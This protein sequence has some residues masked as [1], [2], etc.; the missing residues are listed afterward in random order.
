M[1]EP[2]QVIGDVF[3][4]LCKGIDTPVSLAAW[5]RFKYDQKSLSEQSVN[6]A[7]YTS[8]AHFAPD[9]AVVSF[10]SKFEG[11][12]T[13]VDT[14]EV[15]LS[16]FAAAELRCRDTNNRIRDSMLRGFSPRVEAV[17]HTAKRKIA[18]VL[19]P[20]NV[21]KVLRSPGWGP[22]ATFDLPRKRAMVGTKQSKVPTVT[23]G[24]LPYA[25]IW[26]ETDHHWFQAISGH[27]V[28]GPYSVLPSCFKIVEGNRVI[29]VPK[30]AKTD[31]TI[32]AEPTF[33]GFLQKAVG[34]YMRRRLKRSGVD[35]DNQ[36]INQIWAS[37]ALELDLATI[38]LKA[39]SDTIARELVFLLLPLDWALFLD[40]L[41]S[42]KGKV[43][44]KWITY[45]K[46]SSMGNSFTFELETLIFWALTQGVSQDSAHVVAVYG[47]DIICQKAVA[48]DL[49][50]VLGT[51][52]FETNESK[53]YVTGAFYESC[54]KHYFS[55]RDVTP[56][57]QKANIA[58]DAE[59]IR[60][61][62]RLIRLAYRWGRG[63]YLDSTVRPAWRAL[64]RHA[65]R[66]LRYEVPLHPSVGDD[67][68]SVPRS[69]FGATNYCP[70]QGY[71]CKV[72]SFVPSTRRDDVMGL[73]ANT[74]RVIDDRPEAVSPMQH[75]LPRKSAFDEEGFTRSSE[76]GAF[77]PG[78]RWVHPTRDFD[79]DW[80]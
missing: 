8:A 75:G 16:G 38:D 21:A 9:Y 57:Y 19:G 65:V 59:A 35:L 71:H 54:G 76:L 49:I 41:R 23:W 31:R 63:N 51:L 2:S 24:A 46:F 79:T 34:R 42:P 28:V 50:D 5:L 67:G 80:I 17:L 61:G 36:E 48:A 13:G 69:E 78:K 55:G 62:N 26:L 33:N 58:N 40:S 60:C 14:K 53:S 20:L 32:A 22:G 52:G 44:G 12:N 45:E 6:P 30:N 72:L 39:A 47:D 74:L 15:A 7:N 56:A 64:R 25:R 18:A 4:A 77:R 66:S 27:E 11:L 29:T 10:L 1:H 43:S 70:N 73:L 37:L 68:W 3:F